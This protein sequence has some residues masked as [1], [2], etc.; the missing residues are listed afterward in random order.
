MSRHPEF[1]DY[2]PSHAAD[3]YGFPGPFP[4][5]SDYYPSEGFPIPVSGR[6]RQT[7]WPARRRTTLRPSPVPGYFAATIWNVTTAAF[8]FPSRTLLQ[9]NS[10]MLSSIPFMIPREAVP[11]AVLVLSLPLAEQGPL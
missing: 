10:G 7:P 9:D 2:I 1:E 5:P 6:A 3:T 11:Y 8:Q 4:E